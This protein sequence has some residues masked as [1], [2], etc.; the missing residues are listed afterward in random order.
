MRASSVVL[1]SLWMC[2]WVPVVCVGEDASTTFRVAT[3]NLNWANRHL[4]QAVEAIRTSEA[5]IVFLQE[6]TPISERFLQQQL[7]ESHP[8]VHFVG[9]RRQFGAERFGFAS[10]FPLTDVSFEPPGAGL[11]GSFRA[12]CRIDETQVTLINVHLNPF[13]FPRG[14]GIGALLAAMRET[15]DK[16]A[17]EIAAISRRFDL[18]QPAII[19]GDFNSLSTFNAPSHLTKL[20]LI[21]SFASVHEDADTH[22]TWR[23]PTRP[24]PMM[25]RIDYIFHTHHFRTAQSQILTR[26]GSDHSLVASE[27]ILVKESDAADHR[28]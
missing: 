6:T 15:E 11:F 24:L 12:V 13:L 22:A 26:P 16:H 20:G 18:S 7:A 21:D 25:L 4:D 28:P 23:W 14:S 1:A 3:Y 10:R 27:L 19:A 17:A 2:F 5:D 8:H 9:H